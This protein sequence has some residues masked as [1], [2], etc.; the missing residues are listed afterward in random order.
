MSSQDHAREKQTYLYR[1]VDTI[2]FRA[3]NPHNLDLIILVL[4]ESV[5]G[6]ICASSQ[7]HP[8]EI[9]YLGFSR[10]RKAET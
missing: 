4:S 6:D 7:M 9:K 3:R 8:I 2:F 5:N 10:V 1:L